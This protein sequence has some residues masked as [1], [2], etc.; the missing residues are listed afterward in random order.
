MD[1][2]PADLAARTVDELFLQLICNDPDLLAAE[3]DAIIAVEWPA[4]PTKEGA[5]KVTSGPPARKPS[6]LLAWRADRL[7][8]RPRHPGVGGWA[9]QRSPPPPGTRIRRSKGR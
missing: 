5:P 6:N 2:A 4:P 9:R 3:F 8:S 1:T 7:V